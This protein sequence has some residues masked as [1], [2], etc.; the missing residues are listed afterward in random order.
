MLLGMLL[1]EMA[2][3]QSHS[4]TNRP[5]PG[6]RQ[7]DRHNPFSPGYVDMTPGGFA[8]RNG[9]YGGSGFSFGYPT[10]SY[11]YSPGYGDFYGAGPSFFGDEGFFN[12]PYGYGYDPGYP[13]YVAPEAL[14]GQ[15]PI[16]N[17]LDALPQ[18]NPG[19][20]PNGAIVAPRDNPPIKQSPKP[21]IANA[22][23]LARAGRLIG[24]GDDHFAAQRYRDANERYRNATEAAPDLVEAFFRQGQALLATGLYELA[25]KAFKRGMKLEPNWSEADFEL[26]RLYGENQIA[27]TAHLE[28]VAAA[29]AEQPHDANLLLLVAIQLHFGGQP[30]RARPIFQKAVGRLGDEGLNL[31]AVLAAAEVK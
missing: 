19:A 5:V 11:Y 1:P 4:F 14:F 24:A 26:A 30:E 6:M 3:G 23:S 12:P 22:E 2:A 28:A 20:N 10:G 13:L 15:G 31:D 16:W 27:K 25:G 18:A 9:Y 7:A 8:R 21:R 17:G 29:A